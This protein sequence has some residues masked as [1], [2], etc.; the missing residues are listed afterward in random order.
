MSNLELAETRLTFDDLLEAVQDSKRGRWFLKEYESRIQKRDTQSIID[1]ISKLESRM[2]HLGPQSANPDDI[3]KVRSAIANARSDLFKLGMGH[4][5]L[6]KEGRLFAE[7]AE[8]ARKV[9]PEAADKSAGIVRTLQLV[10]EIDRTIS[11][12]SIDDRGAKFFAADSN[13]FDRPVN[14]AKPVLV[15]T[16]PPV[17]EVAASKPVAPKKEEPAPTGAKLV[18]RKAN[19]ASTP[20]QTLPT[21]AV[22]QA[23]IVEAAI[24]ETP[25]SIQQSENPRIVIIR[26]RAEDM[27]E[28]AIGEPEDEASAA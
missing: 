11:P 2:E 22:Q 28:V 6:S 14:V 18:I 21:P 26:R 27:P 8:M 13:L 17:A 4:E 23:A 15:E 3:G 5:A 20:D 16:V 7:M 19:Q 25:T 24:S 1:A 12:T 10:D 9:M